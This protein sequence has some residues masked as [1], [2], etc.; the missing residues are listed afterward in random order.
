MRISVLLPNEEVSYSRFLLFLTTVLIIFPAMFPINDVRS[1]LNYAFDCK[2]DVCSGLLILFIYCSS[3]SLILV[4][5]DKIFIASVL[6]NMALSNSLI[7]LDRSG[8]MPLSHQ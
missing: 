6:L 1:N 7:G 3:I 5:I 2:N 8:S 4:F